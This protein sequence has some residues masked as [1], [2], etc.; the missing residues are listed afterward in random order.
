MF[1][2]VNKNSVRPTTIGRCRVF[3]DLYRVVVLSCKY[4]LCLTLKPY[5]SVFSLFYRGEG[6]FS[7]TVRSKPTASGTPC[8]RTGGRFPGSD[9]AARKRLLLTT[10]PL[11]YEDIRQAVATRA[12]VD[13]L[14]SMSH[15]IR[16]LKE[17]AMDILYAGQQACK[18][19][20][21]VSIDR[22]QTEY[23]TAY[24]AAQAR[25]KGA[26]QYHHLLCV[27]PDT[28]PVDYTVAPRLQMIAADQQVNIQEVRQEEQASG[29]ASEPEGEDEVQEHAVGGV[30]AVGGGDTVGRRYSRWCRGAVP[31]TRGAFSR[32]PTEE[33]PGPFRVNFDR[34]WCCGITPAHSIDNCREFKILLVNERATKARQNSQ[35][36]RSLASKHW[37]MKC[38]RKAL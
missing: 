18:T 36:F 30:S 33:Q 14:V 20:A 1:Y 13:R 22:A 17:F 11:Q 34:C 2:C 24:L 32:P 21:R 35:Y 6:N 26:M 38:P 23:L 4:K 25:L 12:P 16:Q 15:D 5:V 28:V 3:Y 8:S 29:S 27:M 31:R 37:M 10:F 7:V 19:T 9:V